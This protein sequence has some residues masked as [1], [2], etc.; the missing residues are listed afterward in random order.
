MPIK[1]LR[2]LIHG[3]HRQG[4]TVNRYPISLADA[5]RVREA[6]NRGGHN[7][8]LQVLLEILFNPKTRKQ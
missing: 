1:S 3:T 6:E 4:A 8:G 2:A 7:E 5:K